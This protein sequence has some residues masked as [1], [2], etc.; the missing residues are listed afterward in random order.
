MSDLG[1]PKE[2]DLLHRQRFWWVIRYGPTE[3]R[4]DWRDWHPDWLIR[5]ARWCGI[6][7]E[8]GDDSCLTTLCRIWLC[9]HALPLPFNCQ[10]STRCGLSKGLT[11]A[12]VPNNTPNVACKKAALPLPIRPAT[13]C[14]I[15]LARRLPIRLAMVYRIWLG[16]QRPIFDLVI[17]KSDGS[18]W[19][20]EIYPAPY[21][22]ACRTW[23]THHQMA[24][25][26]NLVE[27]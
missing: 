21:A 19:N 25:S 10:L 17:F 14:R 5:P 8:Q 22:G 2:L 4:F 13:L 9:P 6:W 1:L 11:S 15:W 3:T 12:G 23:S 18:C 7:L 16:P 27:R 20:V 24:A 26:S